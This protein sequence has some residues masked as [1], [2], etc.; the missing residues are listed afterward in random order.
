MHAEL[1]IGCLALS[2]QGRYY[3]F[4]HLWLQP[5]PGEWWVGRG[6]FSFTLRLPPS[7][8]WISPPYPPAHAPS[9]SEWMEWMV[10]ETSL[11]WGLAPQCSHPPLQT[12]PPLSRSFPRCFLPAQWMVTSDC[13]SVWAQRVHKGPC[14]FLLSVP[15]HIW[16][17][18]WVRF[19]SSQQFNSTHVESVREGIISKKTPSPQCPGWCSLALGRLPYAILL[20]VRVS[21]GS[22]AP[23]RC[24]R[25]SPKIPG[26]VRAWG[27]A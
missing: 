13:K 22:L 6:W 25:D 11:D 24:G 9:K 17:G 18:W 4:T 19:P 15:L 10:S 20:E 3:N 2:K 8:S 27:Q 7:L 12:P 16:W 21:D 26:V 1:S 14:L 5:S 23:G